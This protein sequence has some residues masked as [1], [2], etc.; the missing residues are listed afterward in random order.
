MKLGKAALWSY[1][2]PSL[3]LCLPEIMNERL[4]VILKRNQPILCVLQN[5][6]ETLLNGLNGEVNYTVDQYPELNKENQKSK[7]PCF[8]LKTLKSGAEVVNIIRGIA[9][10][11]RGLIGQVE[12]LVKLL[13]VTPASPAKA[14]RSF[15]AFRRLKKDSKPQ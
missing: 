10:V 4:N 13:L 8:G 15:S 11:V 2:A 6:E 5:L 3:T 1:S 12:T 14:E 7:L 9:V